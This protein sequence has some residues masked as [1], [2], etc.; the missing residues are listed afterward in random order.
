[1]RYIHFSKLFFFSIA[2][3][4]ICLHP[5]FSQKKLEKEKKEIVGEGLALYTLILANWTSNDLYYE[6]EFNTSYV[7]GYLS[8]RQKDTIKTIFWREIDTTSAEYKAKNFKQ[9]GDTGIV[10]QQQP[11]KTEDLRVI[12]KTICYPKMIVKKNNS[13]IIEEEEREPTGQEKILMD[14]RSMVYK[15]INTDTSFFKL[16]AETSLKAV[17]FDAGKEV[18]V[19]VYS[20]VKKDGIVP[21]GGDY[22]LVYDKKTKM[23]IEKTDL[24]KDCVFISIQYK[25][26]SY[27][28]SKATIHTHKEGASELITPT[29]IAT[30]L[31]YKSQLEWDEH[32]VVAGKYTCVF[33]L[34]DK[35]LDIIPT[36]E[37]EYLKKKKIQNAE[38]EQKGKMH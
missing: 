20:S 3:V 8:Y 13:E 2:S 15:E 22:L 16:Y 17:P 32:H 21:F 37:F 7:K 33:T 26:K 38:E 36:S 34:V 28:V 29:D 30:L 9:A 11:K 25:G 5:A 1:M 24:H 18:K 19:Y 27:D 6:N 14:Y 4:F 12:I 31:L 23:L 10:A 35:K